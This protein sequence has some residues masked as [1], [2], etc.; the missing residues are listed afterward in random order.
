MQDAI[1]VRTR[2][3]QCPPGP[4]NIWIT[5]QQRNFRYR[6]EKNIN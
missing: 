3:V 4:G 2:P 6:L 5:L 1:V